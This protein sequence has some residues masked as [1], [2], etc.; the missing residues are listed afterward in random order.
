VRHEIDQYDRWYGVDGIFLDRVAADA[1][2]LPY[3]QRVGR[4]VHGS[5]RGT[6]VLNPGSHPDEAYAELADV[7]VTFEGDASTYLQA[8]MPPWVGEYP[9]SRF[10]HLIYG[11]SE[12]QLS[13]V[14]ALSRSRRAGVVYVTDRPLPNPWD[15]PASYWEA[16][17]NAVGQ[18]GRAQHGSR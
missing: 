7:I 11:T 18:G 15:M 5:L 16:E 14:L 8:S 9:V 12:S 13:E 4:Y 2:D 6:L 10:W 1:A 3:Y 17:V